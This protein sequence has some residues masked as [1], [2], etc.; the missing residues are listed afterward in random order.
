MYVCKAG[1][2]AIRKARHGSIRSNADFHRQPK[3][4][5]ETNELK[6]VSSRVIITSSIL[7]NVVI[8]FICMYLL[9]LLSSSQLKYKIDGDYVPFL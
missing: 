9:S 2:M 8:K 7:G 4:S 6:T 5:I 3:E 1:H